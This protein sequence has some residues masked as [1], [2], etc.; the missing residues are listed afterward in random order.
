MCVSV[1]VCVCV[2][3]RHRIAPGSRNQN[4]HTHQFCVLLHP[5][6]ESTVVSPRRRLDLWIGYIKCFYCW[7]EV[8]IRFTCSRAKLLNL[9]VL[10]GHT[11]LTHYNESTSISS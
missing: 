2:L 3:D 9:R 10:S 1:C 8:N 11:M 5:T 4:V 6:T 7:H